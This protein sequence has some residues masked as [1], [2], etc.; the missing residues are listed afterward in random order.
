MSAGVFEKSA[1]ASVI[2]RCSDLANSLA[3]YREKLGWAPIGRGNEGGENFATFSVGGLLVSLWELPPD[4][5]PARAGIRG[6]YVAIYIH[7]DVAALRDRLLDRGVEA[8]DTIQAGNFMSFR[9]ADPD[10][11]VFEVTTAKSAALGPLS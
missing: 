7:A 6:A 5:E 4:A 2:L 9:F 1:T 11:N 8:R 10:G 3:W